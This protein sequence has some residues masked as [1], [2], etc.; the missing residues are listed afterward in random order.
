M[1]DLERQDSEDLPK[2]QEEDLQALERMLDQDPEKTM[3]AVQ[4][5]WDGPV[6]EA[7][8]RQALALHRSS[9]LESAS[10]LEAP[11]QDLLPDDFS[12]D[13]YEPSANDFIPL[14]TGS[15]KF[16]TKADWYNWALHVSRAVVSDLTKDKAP[17]P[18]HDF[19]AQRT[20]I[21]QRPAP[22]AGNPV[23]VA[24]F[25]DFGTGL[26]HSLYIARQFERR[27][28]AY[29]YLIHLGDVYYA[30]RQAEFDNYFIRPL[31]PAI[32]RS[33]LLTMNANHEMY[34]KGYPYFRYMKSRRESY[35]HLQFQEGSYFCLR[36]G[37]FQIVAIDSDYFENSRFQEQQTRDWLRYVLDS[38]RQL[39][40]T[41]IFL[42]SNEPYC[43]NKQGTTSLHDDLEEFFPLID[44]WFWGNTHY[45]ALFDRSGNLPI[46]S[47]I[48][49]GG[50]PYHLSEY[51]LLHSPRCSAQVRFVENTPRYPPETGLRQE[52][53]NNGFCEMYLHRDGRIELKYIDWMKRV[54]HST[55]LARDSHGRLR[56][57]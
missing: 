15:T 27:P 18:R 49:H 31:E 48:G 43:Y 13:G 57:V 52:P 17:F 24:L 51:D 37:D 56:F 36:I 5:V 46:G 22:L 41:T 7:T 38:G 47:C 55:F 14:R 53:G 34:S 9:F 40:L 1:T 35:P 26:A 44:L 20:F 25:S 29:D 42:S 39:S 30:G 23:E 6:D 28:R 8:L 54:R 50:Y 3:N 16:E 11:S 21:Y 2:A 45:C 19:S 12:F 33:P 32:Q 10:H 4:R